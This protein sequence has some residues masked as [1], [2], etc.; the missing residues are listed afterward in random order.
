MG[1]KLKEEDKARKPIK[2][3]STLSKDIQQPKYMSLLSTEDD[4]SSY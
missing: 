1:K 2:A 3:W 4:L